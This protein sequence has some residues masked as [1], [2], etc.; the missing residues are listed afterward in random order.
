LIQKGTLG[1]EGKVVN[2]GAATLHNRGLAVN[3]VGGKAWEKKGGPENPGFGLRGCWP[4][5]YYSSR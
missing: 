2:K 1:E 4:H 3:Q 5:S